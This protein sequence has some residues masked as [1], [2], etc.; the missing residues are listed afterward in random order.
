[1]SP[2]GS[3]PGG[4]VALLEIG[5]PGLSQLST[6][7][8]NLLSVAYDNICHVLHSLDGNQIEIQQF[9][10]KRYDSSKLY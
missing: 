8:I 5:P 4:L 2:H 9:E 10:C 1:M 7:N 6:S 3:G